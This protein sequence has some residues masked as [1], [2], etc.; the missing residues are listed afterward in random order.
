[1]E[2]P[3]SSRREPAKG[4]HRSFA[5]IWYTR[6]PL[7]TASGIAEKQHSLHLVFASLGVDVEAIRTSAD[8]T[9]RYSHFTHH[10]P[11]LFREGGP[12]APIWARS[13]GRETSLIG[14]TRTD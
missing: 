3:M 4:N 1:M 14:I 2:R 5:K 6:S 7:P 9:V 8:R 12:V 13:L 10:H 11:N